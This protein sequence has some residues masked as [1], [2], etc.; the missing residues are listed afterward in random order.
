MELLLV[1]RYRPLA[2]IL[3]MGLEEEGFAVNTVEDPDTARD[4]LASMSCQVI[5]LDL[6]AEQELAVLRKWRT[7][8][9]N[10]PV[11]F[12]SNP[13]SLIEKLNDL[14]LGPGTSLRKP[15]GFDELLERLRLLGHQNHRY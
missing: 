1:E 6:P 7:A 11:L 13:G 9:I 3:R 5:L 4:F 10:T 14:G 2:R 12:L 15:F 8:K